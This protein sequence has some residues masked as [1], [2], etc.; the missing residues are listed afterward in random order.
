[1]KKLMIALAVTAMAV[2]ANAAAVTW[3]S[4]TIA[5]PSG[6]QAGKGEVNAYLFNVAKSVYDTYAAMTDATALSDAIYSAYG[7]SIASADATKASTAKGVAKL[8]DG[9]DY[10]VGTYYAVV[11]YTAT[12]GGKDYFMGNYASAAVEATMDV[13]TSFLANYIAGDTS[14]GA[15]AW[16]T[17]AVPEPTSGLLLLLGMAGLALKRKRA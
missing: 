17:A 11:L 13:E 12:E 10:G 7:S 14:K 5:L 9:S 15:T 16:S 1:M 3:G 6:T 4:G 8:S 2:C